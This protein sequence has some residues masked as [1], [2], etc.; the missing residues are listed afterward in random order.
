MTESVSSLYTNAMQNQE[1]PYP[2]LSEEMRSPNKKSAFLTEDKLPTDRPS[3]F[4]TKETVENMTSPFITED[5]LPTDRPAPFLEAGKNY[6]LDLSP[7]SVNPM[8]NGVSVGP[9]E[10]NLSMPKPKGVIM[11]ELQRD[12]NRQFLTARD[13][14][15]KY[16]LSYIQ[17]QDAFM[18]L[19]ADKNGI[20]KELNLPQNSTVSYLL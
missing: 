2:F 18:E 5:M 9:M 19:N 11:S 6:E 1:R 12:P 15:K 8:E 16:N 14:A 3:P 13:I 7:L 4:L 10:T 17:A 20:V